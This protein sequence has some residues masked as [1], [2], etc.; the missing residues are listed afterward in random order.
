MAKLVVNLRTG[1]TAVHYLHDGVNRIGRAPDN[2]IQIEDDFLSSHHAELVSHGGSSLIRDLNSTNGTFVANTR[3]KQHRLADCEWIRFGGVTALFETE[4]GSPRSV[5]RI[6]RKRWIAVFG[7]LLA[8][9]A[10]A[11]AYTSHLNH[12]AKPNTTQ[13]KLSRNEPPE[14]HLTSRTE[15]RQDPPHQPEIA[16]ITREGALPKG[17]QL[18]HSTDPTDVEQ[19][20]SNLQALFKRRYPT[21]TFNLNT[22]TGSCTMDANGHSEVKFE[23]AQ[24][25]PYRIYTENKGENMDVKLCALEGG[26]GRRLVFLQMPSSAIHVRDDFHKLILR[27]YVDPSDQTPNEL[28]P[29]KKGLRYGPVGMSAPE[30]LETAYQANVPFVYERTQ[31]LDG[32]ASFGPRFS[33]CL[34]LSGPKDNL[35]KINIVSLLGSDNRANKEFLK[36]HIALARSIIADH[37]D[38]VVDQLETASLEEEKRYTA[39]KEIGEKRRIVLVR[40]PLQGRALIETGFFGYTTE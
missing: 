18:A 8:I 23:L 29:E 19:I 39:A 1:S 3:V 17:T 22:K 14:R 36:R 34:Q 4:A 6:S 12:R 37:A 25:D 31:A 2:D 24:L 7:G 35:V 11:L 30:V 26:P 13:N 40:Q 20:A 9:S 38:W 21:G 27:Y 5:K 32:R 16:Q 15:T 33:P 28:I 10:I